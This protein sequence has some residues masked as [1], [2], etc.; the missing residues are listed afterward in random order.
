M[1]KIWLEGGQWCLRGH[2]QQSGKIFVSNNQ[3]VDTG[4]KSN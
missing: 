3:S 2:H 1:K 4:S